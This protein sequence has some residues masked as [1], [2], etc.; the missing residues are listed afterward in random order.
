MAT[1]V[2]T[3]QPT[4]PAVSGYDVLLEAAEALVV[5]LTTSWSNSLRKIAS[6]NGSY[7]VPDIPKGTISITC[8]LPPTGIGGTTGIPISATGSALALNINGI[9][10]TNTYH[11]GGSVATQDFGEGVR[12]LALTKVFAVFGISASADATGI[13]VTSF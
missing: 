9:T 7:G 10:Y 4:N 13:P 1:D 2:Y 8:L 3:D 5:V 12:A 11:T 6:L